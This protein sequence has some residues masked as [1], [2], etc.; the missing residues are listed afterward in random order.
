[1]PEQVKTLAELKLDKVKAESNI[2]YHNN[3][4]IMWTGVLTY[5]A[6]EIAKLEAVNAN[7]SGEPTKV[8]NQERAQ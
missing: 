3:Q 4:I 2:K 8:P 5:L 6:Q 1:M 7:D